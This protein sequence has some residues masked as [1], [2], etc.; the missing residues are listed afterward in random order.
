VKIYRGILTGLNE[1]FIINDAKRRGI[2][3]NCKDDAEREYTAAIIKPILRGRDIKRYYYQWAGLWVIIIP[4]GWT[5]KTE[6]MIN[7][8]YLLKNISII[9]ELFKNLKIS[10]KRDDQGDYWW[11]L[12]PCSYYEEFEKE[13]IAWT[14]VGTRLS[15]T[16]IP[17]NFYL[18]APANFL[19]YEKV[20]FLQGVLNSRLICWYYDLIKTKLGENGGRFYIYDFMTIPIPLITSFNEQIV[21]QIDQL[22]DKILSDK[23]ADPN[24][25]TTNLEHEIDNLVYQLYEFTDKEIYLI[26]NN[27]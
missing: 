10:K 17:Q 27:K 26:E 21:K 24:A 4:A 7:Q 5:N 9:N 12:R 14:G 18:N 8:K 15:T 16:I 23:K 2:L 6:V 19:T 13:K 20:K 3:D 11:E 22:V 1:S 25:D